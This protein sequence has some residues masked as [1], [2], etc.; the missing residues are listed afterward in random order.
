M[1]G[2]WWKGGGGIGV[3]SVCARLPWPSHLS[4]VLQYTHSATITIIP[5]EYT[6]R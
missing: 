1:G 5:V 3:G 4:I 6:A 2:G